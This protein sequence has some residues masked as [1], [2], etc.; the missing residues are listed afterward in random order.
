MYSD[1]YSRLLGPHKK[2]E[3]SRCHREFDEETEDM[4]PDDYG[5][6]LC[7]SCRTPTMAIAITW[8][9]EMNS[10]EVKWPH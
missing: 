8:W 9:E 4:E 10:T 7:E 5:G 6:Q 1:F 3:C 2:I